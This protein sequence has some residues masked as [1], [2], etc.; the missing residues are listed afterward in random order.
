MR[1]V[2]AII[3]MHS[4]IYE[5]CDEYGTLPDR[6]EQYG[7]PWHLGYVSCYGRLDDRALWYRETSMKWQPHDA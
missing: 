6:R 1:S 7:D 2:P 4:A 3:R 5:L